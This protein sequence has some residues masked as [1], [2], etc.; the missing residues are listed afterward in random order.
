MRSTPRRS[1]SVARLG[2][3]ALMAGL[4]VFVLQFPWGG[5]VTTDPPTCYGMFGAWTVPCGGWPTLAAG[6]G[7][8]L[9]VWLVL[10]VKEN[11]RLT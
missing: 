3:A 11:P 8:A 1:A 9:L 2:V 5:G 6:V 4:V 10:L 7:T